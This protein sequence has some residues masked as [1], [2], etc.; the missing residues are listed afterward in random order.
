MSLISPACRDALQHWLEGLAALGGASANTIT[1]Y[2]GDVTS[3]LAFM[4]S[5]T[6]GPQGL[7]ALA[8]ISTADMRAWMASERSAG[9]GSR[10]LARK[11]SSVKSFYRWLATR[12]GFEPT[13]VL[14]V[15]A[16]KFQKKLPRPLAQDAARAVI[17]TVEQQSSNDWVAARD[18][19]VV[20]LLY[21]CGLRISEALS[22]TGGDAP[23]PQVLRIKGKGE[24]ERV[25]PVIAAARD[26]VDRYLDLC[27]Y[28]QMQ[29]APLFRGQRGGAL[30]PRQ[31]QG[32]MARTRA[33]LGLPASAT[34]H[35]L[36]HSFA[37][38]LLEAGGDLRA[39]QEL[40]GH[41]SLSTTQA[42]TAVDTAHLME[43]YNRA[44]PK[45]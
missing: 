45:A 2:Q 13:A 20:T 12:E 24:K 4:T 28:P 14:A 9:T 34:P 8:Q 19:A 41:A 5:H 44:H 32:V 36:R 30:N 37:T 43:V 40:M 26:A 33:Q 7:G 21:G 1:A 18:V 15:R 16:P 10:S 23:L 38:H 11:L 39:I 3:F 42:Y 25:V 31:I 35:A 22:L 6:G 17:E 27:P 29:D